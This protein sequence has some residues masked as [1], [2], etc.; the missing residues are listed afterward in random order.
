MARWNTEEM[1]DELD[2]QYTS[3]EQGEEDA[4]IRNNEIISDLKDIQ[5]RRREKFEVTP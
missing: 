5:D 1:P 2:D 4:R 3:I